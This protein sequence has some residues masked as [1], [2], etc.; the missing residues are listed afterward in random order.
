MLSSIRPSFPP[1]DL[2]TVVSCDGAGQT[3]S[4]LVI[5]CSPADAEETHRGHYPGG[6]IISVVG[7]V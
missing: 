3:S 6:D 2:Y 4:R 7:N 1:S 5:A